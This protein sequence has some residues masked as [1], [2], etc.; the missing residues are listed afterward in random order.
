LDNF[1]LEVFQD[2]ILRGD[3]ASR[4]RFKAALLQQAQAPWRH[5]ADREEELRRNSLSVDLAVF[6]RTEGDGLPAADLV[7]WERPV[8]YEVSNIVPKKNGSLSYG[9]Y[10]ALLQDFITRVAT[11]AAETTDFTV[12]TTKAQKTL[13]DLLNAK[14]ATA[15]RRFSAAANKSTGATHPLDQKRW[16]AFLIEAHQQNADLGASTLQ[17]WLCEEDGWSEDM[18]YELAIDYEQARSLLRF[19]DD[20]KV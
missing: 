4:A 8:G 10:N 14:A 2:L 7:L 17:R 6:E 9:Q 15:L 19:Y 13:E 1:M 3:P 16:Y 18:A 5:A 12:E 20:A 11:K